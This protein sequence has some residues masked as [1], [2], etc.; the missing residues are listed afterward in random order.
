MATAQSQQ[1]MRKELAFSDPTKKILSPLF[2]F[3]ATHNPDRQ[4]DD[5]KPQPLTRTV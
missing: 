3:S 2:Y 4:T 1:K 5:R